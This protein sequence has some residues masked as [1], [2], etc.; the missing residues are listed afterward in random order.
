MV[1]NNKHRLV[2]LTRKVEGIV[3]PEEVIAKEID[4]DRHDSIVEALRGQ[5]ALVITL[6]GQAPVESLERK[7]VEAAGDAGVGWM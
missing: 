1:K 4:Y 3:L 6:S 7:L 5:D 2:A